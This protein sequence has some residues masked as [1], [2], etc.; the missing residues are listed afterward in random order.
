MA[1]NSEKN[2]SKSPIS[3]AIS[4]PDTIVPDGPPP[5]I[6]SPESSHAIIASGKDAGQQQPVT[7]SPHRDDVG[8]VDVEKQ[9]EEQP[10]GWW[11]PQRKFWAKIVSQAAGF[12]LMTVWLIVGL[13][14]TKANNEDRNTVVPVVFYVLVILRQ[15]TL[16]LTQQ[17]RERLFNPLGAMLARSRTVTIDKLDKKWHSPLGGAVVAAAILIG[18]FTSP[19]SPGNELKDRAVSL[20]GF[21]LALFGLWIS[22]KHRK[23]VQWR[24]VVVGVL[25]QFLL[26]VFV[27]RSQTGVSRDC[28]LISRL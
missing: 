13:L 14:R 2:V 22:S 23:H 3:P 18:T 16:H 1:T 11:T 10:S 19:A 6:V 15:L 20:L 28:L 21:T 17:H 5:A 26:G 27:M 9:S 7:R 24:P 25:G 4:S 8:I 12:I